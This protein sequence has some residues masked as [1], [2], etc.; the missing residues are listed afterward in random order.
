[1]QVPE[2]R[3]LTQQGADVDALYEISCR[4][5]GKVDALDGTALRAQY[6]LAGDSEAILLIASVSRIGLA[7]AAAVGHRYS[8][9]RS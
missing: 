4:F 9:G 2:Q 5:E 8:A 1:M 7:S 6:E 3:R